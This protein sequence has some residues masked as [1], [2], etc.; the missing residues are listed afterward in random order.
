MVIPLA[1]LSGRTGRTFAG[2]LRFE[3]LDREV[4]YHC[5]TSR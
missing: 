4:R 3:L 2:Q 5:G 1:V